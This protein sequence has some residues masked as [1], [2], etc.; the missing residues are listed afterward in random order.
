MSEQSINTQMDSANYDMGALPTLPGDLM[1]PI[2]STAMCDIFGIRIVGG[3]NAANKAQTAQVQIVEATAKLREPGLSDSER[4]EATIN[5]ALGKAELTFQTGKAA[6]NATKRFG[7]GNASSSRGGRASRGN[8]ESN[9][10][11]SD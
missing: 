5:L 7:S 11:P 3:G 10:G 9:R 8:G 2:G 1:I 6:H 4:H